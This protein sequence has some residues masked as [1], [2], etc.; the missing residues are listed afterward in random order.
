MS[1]V[2]GSSALPRYRAP[3]DLLSPMI[4]RDMR[5]TGADTPSLCPMYGRP[6]PSVPDI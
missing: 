6:T 1:S 3:A 2:A 5:L 4:V